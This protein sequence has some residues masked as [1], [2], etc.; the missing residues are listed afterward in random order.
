MKDAVEMRKLYA[1]IYRSE[2]STRMSETSGNFG[3][4][5]SSLDDDFQIMKREL[6]Q[7]V[8]LGEKLLDVEIK[9]GILHEHVKEVQGTE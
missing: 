5:K 3:V 2:K 7:A 9:R 6:S 1:S 8:I 4:E